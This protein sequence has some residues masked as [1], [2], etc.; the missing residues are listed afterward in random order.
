[1]ILQ[2]LQQQVQTNRD[3]KNFQGLN[4]YQQKR[5]LDHRNTQKQ[6]RYK[7]PKKFPT[8]FPIIKKDDTQYEFRLFHQVQ[9]MKSAHFQSKYTLS[10]GSIPNLLLHTYFDQIV[11]YDVAKLKSDTTRISVEALGLDVLDNICAVAGMS[12]DILIINLLNGSIEKHIVN[13]KR[14]FINHVHFYQNYLVSN[15]NGGFIRIFDYQNGLKEIFSFQDKASVNLTSVNDNKQIAY[16]G[17]RLGLNV[18][19]VQSGTIIHSLEPHSE[20]GFAVAYHPSKN[21]QLASSSEDGS[22]VIYDLRSPKVPIQQFIGADNPIYNITYSKNGSHLFLAESNSYLHILNTSLYDSVQTIEIHGE[23][24][25]IT[26]DTYDENR[27]YF[28][29]SCTFGDGIC[30]FSK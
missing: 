17:D 1:M 29:T 26:N 9:H 6:R 27:F 7:P 3:N 5:Y 10:M 2:P 16:C 13:Q 18:L 24:S 4:S 14:D 19:D 22:A 30:E 8:Q 15:D 11:F 12:G 28:G 25:G 23:I 21:Y 20:F